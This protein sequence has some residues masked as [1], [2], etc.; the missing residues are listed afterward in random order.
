MAAGRKPKPEQLKVI[1]GTFRKDRANP[2]E[3]EAKGNLITAPEHFSSDQK[4]IWDYAVSHAPSGVLRNID[5]S[6]LEIWVTAYVLYREA[7]QRLGTSG[8]VITTKTGY[9]I[10]NPFMVNMNKQAGI[11]IKT[12]AEM[13]FTPSSRSRIVVAE[14]LLKDDPWARFAKNAS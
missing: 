9:P 4:A 8:Q 11:M 10:T 6:I 14:E 1:Q 7:L 5:L 12:A 3:P 2:H 13:G